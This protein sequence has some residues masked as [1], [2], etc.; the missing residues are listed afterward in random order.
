MF[1]NSHVCSS[2]TN[3]LSAGDSVV[4]APNDGYEDSGA[5]LAMTSTE[6][7]GE[8]GTNSLGNNVRFSCLETFWNS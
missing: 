8:E 7:L 5:D 4:W 2:K 6:A 3:L 1:S